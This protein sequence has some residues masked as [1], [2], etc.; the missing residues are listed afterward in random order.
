MSEPA[1]EPTPEEAA[2][3]LRTIDDSWA[4]VITSAGGPRWLWVASGLVV[5]LYCA[6][7]DLFPNARTWPWAVGAFLVVLILILRTRVGS[8]LLGRSVSVSTRSLSLTLKWRLLSLAPLLAIMI[9]AVP[10]ILVLHVPHAR[11]YYGAAAGLY[12]MFVNPGYQ[13]WVL[14][15]R[16]RS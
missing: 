5:F 7:T 12:I 1:S 6:G 2:A 4:Q 11:I 3:A 14:R 9:A 15:R 13:L 16:G 10:I 8:A